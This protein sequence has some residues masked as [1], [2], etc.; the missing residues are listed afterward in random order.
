MYISITEGE[1]RLT[2][3]SAKE[4]VCVRRVSPSGQQGRFV[5]QEAQH[6]GVRLAYTPG[7]QG[8]SVFPWGLNLVSIRCREHNAEQAGEF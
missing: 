5:C 6:P 4:D 8:V 7:Q 2:V 3:K 1:N